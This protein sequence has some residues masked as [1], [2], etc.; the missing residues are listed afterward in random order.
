[1]NAPFAETLEEGVRALGI[2]LDVVALG[3]LERYADRLLA[4]NRKV[5]LTAITDPA[6]SRRSISWTAS[7]LCRS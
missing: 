3:K 5:N 7:R 6:S 2:S 1:M 4:W